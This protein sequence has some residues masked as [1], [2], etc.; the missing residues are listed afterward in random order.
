VGLEDA[1]EARGEFALK[2]LGLRARFQPFS[3]SVGGEE[4]RIS[5]DPTA[6]RWDDRGNSNLIHGDHPPCE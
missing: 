2:V 6:R 4:I 1:R 3:L 5:L